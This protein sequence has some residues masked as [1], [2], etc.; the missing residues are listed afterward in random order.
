MND[1]L[2]ELA[3]FCECELDSGQKL[4][5]AYITNK[6]QADHLVQLNKQEADVFRTLPANFKKHLDKMVR[7]TQSKKTKT[8]SID[9]QAALGA[10]GGGAGGPGYKDMQDQDLTEDGNYD[11]EASISSLD[12]EMVLHIL[13]TKTEHRQTV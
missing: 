11:D 7:L 2:E 4:L 10:G 8:D 13:N 12:L 5:C 9:D 3:K 6:Y 1:T